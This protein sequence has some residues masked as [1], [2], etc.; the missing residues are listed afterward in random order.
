[1]NLKMLYWI[2]CHSKFTTMPCWNEK[3]KLILRVLTQS[4]RVLQAEY[5]TTYARMEN[6]FYLQEKGSSEWNN[7]QIFHLIWPKFY[8]K[9]VST[10]PVW[11]PVLDAP[12]PTPL[13]PARYW[14]WPGFPLTWNKKENLVNIQC[15]FVQ[16]IFKALNKIWSWLKR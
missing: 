1:M 16:L 2:I 6:R 9:R 10:L 5:L 3:S 12:A 7:Q 15:V 4:N 13:W 8:R 14:T 11:G